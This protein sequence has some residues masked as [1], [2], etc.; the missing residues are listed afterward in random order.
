MEHDSTCS[1]NVW[2]DFKEW[3]HFSRMTLA[4]TW[5]TE[6]AHCRGV[7]LVGCRWQ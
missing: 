1:G 5:V 4:G 6:R 2:K 3:T 7:R